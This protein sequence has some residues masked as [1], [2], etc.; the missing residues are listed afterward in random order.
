MKVTQSKADEKNQNVKGIYTK[1]LGTGGYMPERILTNADLEKIVDTTDEWIVERSGI[2]SRHIMAPSETTL[3][4][5]EIAAMRAIEASGIDKNKIGLII[6]ATVTP[7]NLF[8]NTA[9]MLQYRL[10]INENECPAFDVSAACSGFIYALSIAD[11][12]IKSGE[13]EYVLIIG[14]ES[15][16]KTVDWTDRSTC[17][18][19]SDGAGAAVLGASDQPGVYSTHLH[20]DGAYKDLVYL[21]GNLYEGSSQRHLIMRGNETF[22]IAVKKLGSVVDETLKHNNLTKDDINWLIPHQANL[23]IIQAI[24]KKLNIDKERV[25]M[26]IEEHANSSAASVPLAMDLAIRDGRIK[27]GDLMLLEAFGS[28]VTWGAALVRY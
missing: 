16:T 7:D 6:F 13:V 1:I 26:T 22:K 19:F 11:K 12:Y 4:M 21:S 9:S 27:R 28:G 25:V 10:G 2:R 5:A 8:P 18:L 24:A 3:S 23:R 20:A 15:L 17:I 14:A